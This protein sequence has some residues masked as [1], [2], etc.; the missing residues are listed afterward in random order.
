MWVK[1]R[2]L[3]AI[4][5]MRLIKHNNVVDGGQMMPQIDILVRQQ[6]WKSWSLPGQ[7]AMTT[8]MFLIWS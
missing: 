4:E 5:G 1:H 7:D 8:I 6:Q 2:Y 3:L